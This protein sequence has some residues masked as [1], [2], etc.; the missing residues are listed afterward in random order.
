M[1]NFCMRVEFRKDKNFSVAWHK[2]KNILGCNEA[3][4]FLKIAIDS[5]EYL[6]S[7][8]K[9]YLLSR[10]IHNINLSKSLF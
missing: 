10:I 2:N 6:E 3:I 9:N 8:D 4:S 5:Q 1:T 7:N